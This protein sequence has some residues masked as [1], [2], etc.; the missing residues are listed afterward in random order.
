MKWYGW[1]PL[2]VLVM[3]VSGHTQAVYHKIAFS[4]TFTEILDGSNAPG[5]S[6]SLA[7]N[8]GITVGDP[9]SGV[10]SWDTADRESMAFPAD[11]V[12]SYGYRLATATLS[13]NNTS[14]PPTQKIGM[15]IFDNFDATIPQLDEYFRFGIQQSG[16]SPATPIDM[17]FYNGDVAFFDTDTQTGTE[18]IFVTFDTDLSTITDLD[19][20]DPLPQMDHA[21]F[22]LLETVNDQTT[23]AGIALLTQYSLGL[24]PADLDLD[25]DVDGVDLGLFFAS[26][27]GPN[28]GPPTD[29]HADLDG[30]DDVD[31]VDLGQAFGA[32]TGPIT[33][34][35]VPEP[36]TL[37]LLPIVLLWRRRRCRIS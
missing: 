13:L 35:Q 19:E 29:P 14:R 37:A 28:N 33:P 17:L 4:G 24:A 22:V 18:F 7:D 23:A 20:P 6:F 34:A 12:K 31:G 8:A 9:F 21:F 25:G 11:G 3:G 5:G 27:T 15:G 2:C 10:V 32:F 30:D 1:M 16:V 36:A 26:F